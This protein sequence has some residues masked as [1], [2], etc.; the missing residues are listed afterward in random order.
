MQVWLSTFMSETFEQRYVIQAQH[1]T[2]I[3]VICQNREFL[4]GVLEEKVFF[5]K[6]R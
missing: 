1:L 4:C 3:N 5:S 2:D 6:Q